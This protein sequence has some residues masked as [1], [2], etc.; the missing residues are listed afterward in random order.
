M[1]PD[2]SRGRSKRAAAQQRLAA[3]RAA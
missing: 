2:P 1:S 3:K